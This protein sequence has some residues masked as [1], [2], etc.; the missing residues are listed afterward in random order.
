MSQSLCHTFDLQEHS[1]NLNLQ[2]G[3]ACN[4]NKKKENFTNHRVSRS[5]SSP[6]TSNV[7]VDNNFQ[8]QA[9]LLPVGNHEESQ[10]ELIAGLK[11]QLQLVK[12][13]CSRLEELCQK[14]RLHWLEE[15]YW[16]TVLEGYAP[17]R[18]DTCSPRQTTWDTPSPIQSDD[19]DG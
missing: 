16:A 3:I 14:Y 12:L 17:P 9:P 6:Q 13:G 15:N 4:T 2:I 7:D 11:E 1:I 18:I 10:A 19:E 8:D 5:K